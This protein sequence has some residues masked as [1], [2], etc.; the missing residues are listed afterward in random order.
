MIFA[1]KLLIASLAAVLLGS[2]LNA[3]QS[4]SQPSTGVP[5]LV[6]FSGKAVDAQGKTIPGVSGVIFAI[7]PEPSGGAALWMETQNV[8]ADA[9]GNYTIQLGATKPEGLPLDLFTSGAARWLGVTIN[10]GQEQPRILLLSV[11]YALK[12]ADAETIGGL[13]PSAFVLAAPPSSNGS[14]TSAS[15]SA[16]VSASATPAASSDVTTSGGTVNALPLWTSGTNIQSSTLTQIGTGQSAKI[17]VNIATPVSTL[18]VNGGETVRGNLSLPATGTATA[19]AGKNSRPA[20]FTASAFNRTTGAAVPQNFRWQAEPVGNDSTAASGSLNLLYGVGTNP[21][22]ETGLHIASNGR[23]TFAAGQSFPGTV[24]SVGLSAPSS[25][26]TVTGSPVTSAGTLALNWTVA[27][28]NGDTANAIVKRDASGNFAGGFITGVLGIEGEANCAFCVAVTGIGSS[29]GTGVIGRGS[30][31]VEGFAVDDTGSTTDTAGVYGDLGTTSATG[32]EHASAGVWGDTGSSSNSE[33]AVLGTADHAVAGLFVNNS[34]AANPLIAVNN[35]QAGPIFLAENS[36]GAFCA[37]DS[38]GDISCTGSKNAVVPL[39]GGKRTVALSAIESPQ[40]WFEDFGSAELVNGVAVITLDPD[41]A[42][43]V[44]PGMDYKVFPVPN[45]DCRGLYVTRKTATSFE[46]RELGGGGSNV[47]FD[48]RITA[49]RRRYETVR[50]ADHTHETDSARRMGE[51]MKKTPASPAA[52]G[53]TKR[54]SQT[55]AG[56]PVAQ[57]SGK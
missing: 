21:I 32:S 44:N 57:L 45:G 53:R 36:S 56:I 7:Y 11:P 29:G 16:G 18:D 13:P 51:R 38:N 41:F 19:T 34:S 35:N 10:G 30:T 5:R 1:R 6:N 2:F 55:V 17:G 4:V 12:A 8:Q 28:T 42:Q 15:A 9:K 43:T 37:I 52:A 22:A 40:N 48:Y 46:V 20:T 3:Q 26:F 27:P 23:I 31:G 47:S 49:L 54:F 33:A 50:F 14:L 25:D 39:D 24:T